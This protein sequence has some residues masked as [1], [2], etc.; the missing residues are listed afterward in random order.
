PGGDGCARGWRVAAGHDHQYR[1]ADDAAPPAVVP[2]GAPSPPEPLT[3]MIIVPV[4]GSRRI[5]IPRPAIRSMPASFKLRAARPAEA[6]VIGFPRCC[7]LPRRD[8]STPLPP[9]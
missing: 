9:I 8:H 4:F 1:R 7:C 5:V 2:P 6:I 3:Q